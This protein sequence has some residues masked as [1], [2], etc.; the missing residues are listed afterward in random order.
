[1]D[2]LKAILLTALFS[3]TVV[4]LNTGAFAADRGSCRRGERLQIQDLDMRPDPVVEGQHI[5]AWRLNLRFDGRGECMTNLYVREGN[6]I[7]GTVR[8]YA[9]HSGINEIEVPATD[10]FRFR[11]RETCFNVQVDLEGS[12]RAVDAERR[13]CATQRTVWSMR[14]PEDRNARK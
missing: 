14:E 7:V 2:W 12:K 4:N 3:T 10:T 13:F 8:N 5:R 1:M 6:N 9:I 11:N